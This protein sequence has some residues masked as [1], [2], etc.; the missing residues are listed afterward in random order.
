VAPVLGGGVVPSADAEETENPR[1]R[2]T[3]DNS[4]STAAPRQQ[5][6]RMV[7]LPFA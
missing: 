2:A 1:V 5:L 3:L 7:R 6:L 4:A